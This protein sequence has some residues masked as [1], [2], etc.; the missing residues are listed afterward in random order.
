MTRADTQEAAWDA[1]YRRPRMLSP[2]N[3][4]QADVVRFVRALKKEGRRSGA[5]VDLDEWQVLDLG[6]GTGRNAFYLAQQGAKVTGFEISDTA[7]ALAQ[8]FARHAELSI[9]YLKQDIGAP[10]PLLDAS[11]DLVL[12]VTS[13]NSL[14]EQGRRAYL[15]EVA[16]VLKPDGY[17]FVRALCLDGDAHAKTLLR[18]RPGPEAGTYVLPDLGVVERV[19]SEREFR[20]TYGARFRIESLDRTQHYAS[21]SGRKFKR[22]YW[23]ARMCRAD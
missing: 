19:F 15:S 13:S 18:D 14:L 2:H 20:D 6:S 17:F 7:L 16:R 10:Y 23:L 21:V 5:R 1:E 9:T 11:M 3:L 12:D 22:S 8:K 4:P